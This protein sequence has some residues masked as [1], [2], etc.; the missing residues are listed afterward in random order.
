MFVDS[1]GLISTVVALLV[2]MAISFTMTPVAKSFAQKVGAMDV[3]KDARRVHDHPIP[4][5]GGLAI[6]LGFVL[7]VVLFADVNR[8]IQG[9]LLGAVIVVVIGV[10]D[11]I[12]ELKA[13]YKL[14]FQIVA[15]L[16]AVYYGIEIDIVSSINL[17]GTGEYISLGILSIPIT[18][19]WIVAI[20][21]SVNIIDGLDG[22]AVGVSAISSVVMLVV[23]IVVADISLAIIIGALVGACIGF[24]PY[25]INPAKIFMGDS[26]S[27][28][29]GFVLSTVSIIGL[30]KFYAIVS[31]AVPFLVLAFPLFDTAFAFFRRILSGKSPMRPD[32]G[33]L[34]HRL[35]DMGM[36]QKQAVAV[37]YSVST[38]LG[39]VAVV[40][41][42]GGVMRVV[43]I[44]VTFAV[45]IIVT[46][47][48][49]KTTYQ[50]IEEQKRNG[51]NAERRPPTEDDYSD[52][53]N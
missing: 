24:M 28:L 40:L 43:L 15:A 51:N 5:M 52:E 26:G 7:S 49:T 34:H 44:L 18:V 10:I 12:I 32:R 23:S 48:I 47:F 33:H 29:L 45:A 50:A 41:S 21:N 27:L 25:N 46:A 6:F 9:M 22:L 31:F 13:I 39:L 17:F 20:T 2:A 14:V 1:K 35:I 8:Q 11:D 37:L 36:S 30:F 42:T 3:P 4:R 38:V 19:F 16:V 53:E